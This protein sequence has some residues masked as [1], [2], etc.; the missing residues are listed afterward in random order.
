M[1]SGQNAAS[2]KTLLK[3]AAVQDSAKGVVMTKLVTSRFGMIAML[4]RDPRTAQFVGPVIKSLIKT[5]K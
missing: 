3:N 1:L 2:A 5:P 4:L